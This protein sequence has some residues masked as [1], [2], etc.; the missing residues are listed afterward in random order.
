VY[1]HAFVYFMRE[2]MTT[3]ITDLEVLDIHF[4]TSKSLAGAGTFDQPASQ[5]EER[6]YGYNIG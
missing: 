4:P 1:E 3:T 5:L 2:R 6:D